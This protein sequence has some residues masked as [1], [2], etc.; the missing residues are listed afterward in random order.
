MPVSAAVDADIRS[1]IEAWLPEMISLRHHL[2]R[3]PELSFQEHDTA[4]LV[5]DRLT[6]WGYEVHQGLAGTGVVGTLRLGDGPA[7]VGIR[8]D[9]DAL[10]ILE[11]TGLDYASIHD[12]RMHACGHDGHTAIL[13]AAARCLAER[14]RFDG[15]LRVIFQP[16]EEH[17]GGARRMIEDGLFQIL[18]VDRIFGLH[19]MPGLPTG[20]FGFRPGPLTAANDDIVITIR[21]KGG[22]GAFP[23]TAID[24]IVAGAAI[25]MA[26]QGIVARN[27]PAARPAVI[28]VGSFHAGTAANVI[29]DEA[30]LQLSIR[31]TDPDT[32]R[33]VIRRIH[34]VA[35]AQAAS[36]GA[37]ATLEVHAGYPAVINDPAATAF[38]RDAACRM[39]GQARVHDIADAAMGSEDFAFMLEAVPGCYLVV[40][41]GDGTGPTACMI[42]NPGYDFNDHILGDAAA[43]WVGVAEASL[44]G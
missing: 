3:H 6:G 14:R 13:L 12:G 40:G 36:C 30:V 26:L 32:R 41:N 29:P 1:H 44:Q 34:E 39:F 43:L 18:P 37:S 42:H 35:E 23:D 8:A 2:H 9:M 22:H 25:V 7:S 33:L 19:N 15:T 27:V 17:G 4:A 20:V 28:T 24:P 38:A 5:A 11:T 31:T 21:G 10:P 16:A